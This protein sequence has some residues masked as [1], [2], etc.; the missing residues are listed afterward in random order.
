MLRHLRSIR[1]VALWARVV[2]ASSQPKLTDPS[3]ASWLDY[4]EQTGAH[5][6]RGVTEEV[7]ASVSAL[8]G[9]FTCDV[10]SLLA[11]SPFGRP[12]SSTTATTALTD[13][14]FAVRCLGASRNPR[15]EGFAFNQRYLF[16]LL[17]F[18]AVAFAWPPWTEPPRSADRLG[19]ALGLALVLS[20][21]LATARS[22]TLTG[23]LFVARQLAL[24]KVPLVL[25]LSLAFSGG[26]AHRTSGSVTGRQARLA[27]VLP[28][29]S[30]CI[31]PTTWQGPGE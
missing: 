10:L 14:F 31:S 20:I 13:C 18:A 3:V 8:G 6:M 1:L 7:T 11:P 30:P 17:P 16:E 25:S 4:D 21:L 9:A 12:G 2:D 5:V 29:A 22:T 24:L 27:S 15:H 23:S 26:S 19:A 28:G